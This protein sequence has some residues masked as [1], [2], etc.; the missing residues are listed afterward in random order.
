MSKSQRI[1]TVEQ[2][3]ND[4]PPSGVTRTRDLEALGYSR[5]AISRMVQRGQLERLAR[6]VYATPSTATDAHRSLAEVALRAP[7]AAVCLL[8]ALEYHDLTT[9]LPFEVWIAVPTRSRK[10]KL[11]GVRVQF[12]DARYF[13]VGLE[14]VNV[15][16]VPVRVYNAART[17]ADCFKYRHKIGLDVGLEA[18]K[19]GLRERRFTRDELWRMAGVC[20]V[21]RVI[22]P[23][24]ET[25]ASA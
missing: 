10:P 20:R 7:N 2:A 16:G 6:G 21:Q 13:E 15:D 25:A 18:L 4:R 3:R 1:A 5:T 17:V 11:G 23:Y 8:S 19:Q 14:T 9:Q 24:L 22:T 12:F